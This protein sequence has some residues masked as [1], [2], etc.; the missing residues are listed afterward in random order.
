MRCVAEAEARMD[1]GD[2]RGAIGVLDTLLLPDL[3]EVQSLARL[4]EAYLAAGDGEGIDPFE[5]AFALA[6]FSGA[7][8]DNTS[9]SRNELPVGPRWDVERLDALEA[10]AVAWLEPGEAE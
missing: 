4:A 10:R 6:T 3:R 9:F 8:G 5:K 1:A 7:H 2:P